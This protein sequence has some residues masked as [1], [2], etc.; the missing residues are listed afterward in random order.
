MCRWPA[1][2]Y[3]HEE[4]VSLLLE[5]GADPTAELP[6]SF[7][8]QFKNFR[9]LVQLLRRSSCHAAALSQHFK[10]DGWKECVSTLDKVR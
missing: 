8:Q 1:R 9:F 2:R 5:Q 7:L 3:A 4:C 10:D 6:T